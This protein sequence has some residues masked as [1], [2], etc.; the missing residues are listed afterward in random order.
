MFKL[1]Q[2]EHLSDIKD[3]KLNSPCPF[4]YNDGLLRIKTKLTERSESNHFNFPIVLPRNHPVDHGYI[5]SKHEE[6]CHVG[7]QGLLSILREVVWIISG[8]K[9]VKSGNPIRKIKW[10]S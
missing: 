4:E 5:N 1:I 10:F 9:T 2:K 8:W 3:E 7:V 6:N